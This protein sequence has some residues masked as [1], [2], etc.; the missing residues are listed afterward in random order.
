MTFAA[1]IYAALSANPAILL[2]VGNRIY[3]L[4]RARGDVL[5]AIV[6]QV[7]TATPIDALGNT[8]YASDVLSVSCDATTYAGAQDLAN[9]VTAVLDGFKY[10]NTAPFIFAC[11]LDSRAETSDN[12]GERAGATYRVTLDFILKTKG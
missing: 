9:V 5:P 4:V 7:I 2:T 11:R 10:T 6:Y 12:S 8:E 3:P 1:R